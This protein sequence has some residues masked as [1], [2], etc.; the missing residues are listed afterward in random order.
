VTWIDSTGTVDTATFGGTVTLGSNLGALG[1][2]FTTPGYT[3][4]GGAGPFT[5]SLGA[6]GVDASLLASSGRIKVSRL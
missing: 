4:A 6:S 3:M 5:V 2:I 1:L